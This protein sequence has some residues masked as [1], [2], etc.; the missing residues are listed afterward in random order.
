M[1]FS[2]IQ[3]LLDAAAAM[4][5]CGDASH[6]VEENDFSE[7]STCPR[8]P[9]ISVPSVGWYE[10]VSASKTQRYSMDSTVPSF[11]AKDLNHSFGLSFNDICTSTPKKHINY[12]EPL[13]LRY[14]SKIIR[15]YTDAECYTNTLQ[16]CRNISQQRKTFQYEPVSRN[17]ISVSAGPSRVVL[18]PINEQNS[19]RPS[20]HHQRSDERTQETTHSSYGKLPHDCIKPRSSSE[21]SPTAGDVESFHL[22]TDMTRDYAGNNHHRMFSSSASVE[23]S[24]CDRSLRSSSHNIENDNY[25]L[26]SSAEYQP[27][28]IGKDRYNQTVRNVSS[29]SKSIVAIEQFP[30]NVSPV[31]KTS[32]LPQFASMLV[33]N[34]K[35]KYLDLENDRRS[36]NVDVPCDG[37][38]SEV[39]TVINEIAKIS[40]VETKS[41]HVFSSPESR[42]PH[43]YSPSSHDI[44]PH[45]ANDS[46]NNSIEKSDSGSEGGD[47]DDEDQEVRIGDLTLFNEFIVEEYFEKYHNL[48]LM[49]EDDEQ[50]NMEENRGK[51]QPLAIANRGDLGFEEIDTSCVPSKKPRANQRK[52][53]QNAR[54]RGLEYRQ[55]N[56]VIVPARSIKQPCT[57]TKLGCH[58]K[59]EDSTRKKLL[60]NLL[61]LSISLQNQFLGNHIAIRA[62]ARPKVLN[63]RRLFSRSYFLPGFNGRIRVCKDMFMSTFDVKD[64]KIRLLAEKQLIGRG[65]SAD[66]LRSQNGKH[67]TLSDEDREYVTEHIRSFPA[68]SSHYTRE[69]SSKLYLN[70]DLSVMKMHG[71]YAKKCAEDNKVPVQYITYLR[72]FKKMNISFRKPKMDTCGECDKF[73]IT[74]KLSSGEQKSEVEA[75]RDAH[76]NQAQEAY[77]QKRNDVN[78]AKS[79]VHF[80]TAS[81]DLQKCL[82]TPHLTTGIAYYKRQLYT[83]NLTV[84]STHNGTNHVNC[85][86][87][88]ESKAR[89]GSQEIGSCLLK[90]LNGMD[91]CVTHMVY[92]SDRCSGQNH[93][94]IICMTFLAFIEKC[95]EAGRNMQITHKFMTVGH[96][97]ME[98]DSV[99]A[100]IEKAKKRCTVNIETPRD[101]AVFIGAIH[102]KIPFSVHEMDQCEFLAL[103]NLNNYFSRPKKNNTGELIKFKEISAFMYSTD[104]PGSVF[105]KYNLSDADF[106]SF[107]MTNNVNVP[108]VLPEPIADEPISLPDEKL[109]DLRDLIE[110]VS[111]KAYYATL[112][113]EIVPKK[114]GR[115]M[116]IFKDDHFEN[117]L[118]PC[119]DL[120]PEND[121]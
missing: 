71:L 55:P 52:I 72:V 18:R 41:V 111:N 34:N 64:K 50:N 16:V 116:K 70:S 68:Y 1:D 28:S 86:I 9:P 59:Y 73:A 80:R 5:E 90:D 79:N 53:L 62:T 61:K 83:L 3:L 27:Y 17:S 110:F 118:D 25:K 84:F 11:E 76:H 91:E 119:L 85:Y 120:E 106:K 105:Y 35:T 94:T 8:L 88:D 51:Q 7:N 57:C 15:K 22:K 96:S 98:V 49:I 112:L 63:S 74:L 20:Y 4:S 36:C 29:K 78:F 87:W 14:P 99:H 109:R 107:K 95:R 10:E 115:P 108:V 104:D 103:K 75:S 42:K 93:N 56:G 65:I 12:D 54:M 67:K 26:H 32:F 81:F 82:A 44:E 33:A 39:H 60:E 102:R 43:T 23:A 89:R 19:I 117:D 46:A 100:A 92:Y 38:S 114:R 69:K 101:W 30:Q 24:T 58:K 121:F 113:K 77:R 47:I 66:D 2:G 31:P 13:D 21:R 97:H 37:Q 6:R 45:Q 48:T 40:R